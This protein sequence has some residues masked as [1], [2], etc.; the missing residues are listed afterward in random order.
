MVSRM[1]RALAATKSGTVTGRDSA[2]EAA[3]LDWPSDG[4][5][6]AA[7]APPFSGLPA[8]AGSQA[9]ERTH[10]G[11][12]RL[13]RS[14]H[15]VVNYKSRART[16]QRKLAASGPAAQRPQE[17]RIRPLPGPRPVRGVRGH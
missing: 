13:R 8:T 11:V 14:S 3:L 9:D 1:P 7:I 5:G 2:A 17:A 12:M 16:V 6:V 10:T 15:R 4:L